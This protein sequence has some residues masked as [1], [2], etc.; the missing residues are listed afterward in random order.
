MTEG[1]TVPIRKTHPYAPALAL[2]PKLSP[3]VSS[4]LPNMPVNV[5]L[6]TWL[7]LRL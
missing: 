3:K 1:R 6:N 4:L 2:S 7:E 5:L